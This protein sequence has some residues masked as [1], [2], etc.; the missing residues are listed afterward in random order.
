MNCEKLTFLE[1]PKQ[2][3]TI[4]LLPMSL[5]ASLNLGVY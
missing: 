5:S 4:F 2:E 3:K 1:N